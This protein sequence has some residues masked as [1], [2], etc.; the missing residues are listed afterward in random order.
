MVEGGAPP[1]HYGGQCGRGCIT[2]SN[3][4]SSQV[5]IPPA[6]A[7]GRFTL[8]TGAMAREIAVGKDGK[9]EAVAYIDK[10]TKSEKR[11]HARA[12]VVAASACESTRLLLNSKSTLF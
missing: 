11:V 8:I 7:T 10:T 9:A 6:Q 3:F 12:F 2:A 4:S 5:M 1:C